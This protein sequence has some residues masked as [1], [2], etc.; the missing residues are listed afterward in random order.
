MRKLISILLL[1]LIFISHIGYYLL[2]SF[3]QYQ[4]KQTV[5]EHLLTNLPDSSLEQIV[6]EEN[7]TFRWEEDG[8]E[9]YQDGNLYDVV[10]KVNNGHKTILFCIND[11]MEKEWLLHWAKAVKAGNSK[12][13]KQSPTNHTIDL[14]TD[15]VTPAIPNNLVLPQQYFN[16]ESSIV[17]FN[18][19]VNAPPPRLGNS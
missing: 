5:K 8:R 12:G 14:I 15:A 3:Q 18:K 9:F 1:L 19:K 16:I 17:A 4:I 2:Y 11:K 7:N 13:E 6:A 10:R